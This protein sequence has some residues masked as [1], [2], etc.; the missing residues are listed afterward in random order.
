[1]GGRL[2][3]GGGV[4]YLRVM[5]GFLLRWLVSA[6]AL[7]LTAGLLSGIELNG[8]MSILGGALAIGIVNALFRPI[9]FLLTLPLTIVTF[10]LFALVMNALLLWFASVFVPGFHVAGFWSA[11]FGSL[12]L[13]VFTFLITLLIGDD[14]R[15]HTIMVREVRFY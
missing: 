13:S 5:R 9:L 2:W 15:V 10:G 6:L 8:V 4:A 3:C 7:Y 11:F 12:L 14:G 1:M